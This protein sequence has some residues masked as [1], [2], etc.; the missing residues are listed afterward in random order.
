MP[1]HQGELRHLLTLLAQLEQGLLPGGRIQELG[2]PFNGSTV[3]L[4]HLRVTGGEKTGLVLRSNKASGGGTGVAESGNAVEVLLMGGDRRHGI[5]RTPFVLL[6]LVAKGESSGSH[7]V[8]DDSY[9]T[10]KRRFEEG[11]AA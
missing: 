4:G 11:L 10:R 1:Q 7:V 8:V 5:V 2:N 3:V 9:W 6:L